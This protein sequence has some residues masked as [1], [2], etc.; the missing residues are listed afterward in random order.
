MAV[1]HDRYFLDN[2]AQWILE[3]DR[4]VGIPWKVAI[5]RRGWN[6]NRRSG[7]HVRKQESARAQE[8]LAR[9]LEWAK[10]APASRE[11]AKSKARV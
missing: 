11:V 6:R 3:L 2:V 5:T 8:P 4:G 7:W 9:E 1:T 10:M